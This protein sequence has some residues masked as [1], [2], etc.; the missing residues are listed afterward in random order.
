MSQRKVAL[1]SSSSSE[2]KRE[3]SGGEE[4]SECC[5]CC[6]LSPSAPF[7][8][9]EAIRSRK[10]N[11]APLPLFPLHSSQTKSVALD[12]VRRSASDFELGKLER[13]REKEREGERESQAWL[14]LHPYAFWLSFRL[15][16]CWHVSWQVAYPVLRTDLCCRLSK[17]LIQNAW[18]AKKLAENERPCIRLQH[19]TKWK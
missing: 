2:K 11:L 12:Q 10:K 18:T 5:Y 9:V 16:F 13:R 3:R 17:Y 15:L 1:S 7:S 19:I 14:P 4:L 6:S 8:T